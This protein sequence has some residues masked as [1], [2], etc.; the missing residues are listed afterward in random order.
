MTAAD[1][2]IS[3]GGTGGHVFPALA[4][5]EELVARGYARERG[6]LRR[7]PARP[8][9][10][11]GPG[12]R[13]RHRP[14]A[15]SRPPAGVP[16]PP[17]R[18]EPPHRVG[19]RRRRRPG[20]AAGAAAAPA[21]GRGRGRLRVG[22][23]AGRRPPLGRAGGG[24]R[25]RRPPRPGQ[26]DRGAPRCPPRGHPPRDAA[27]RGGG[28]RQSHPARHRRRAPGPGDTPA[29]RGGRRE[30]RGALAEPGGPRPLR[31]LAGPE[32]RHDP[33]RERCPRLRRVPHPAGGAAPTGRRARLPTGPV[34]GAHGGHLHRR[35]AGR[36]PLGRDDGGA[37]RGRGARGAGAAPRRARRPPDRER[38]GAGRGRRR[39]GGPRRRPRPGPPRH[40]ARP[41]CSPTPTVGRAMGDA[42]R[43]LGRPDATARFADL[44]EEVAGA[45]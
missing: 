44:V 3:G 20:G 6:P 45:R 40:R 17:G 1:V 39:G 42:A 21:R 18:A 22:P 11:R 31:P 19:H 13:L 33:P 23:G 41:R 5:A 35:R 24:A 38:G 8:R 4:L 37:H 2:L 26:P 36:L 12:R 15:R 14:P 32:R 29:G 28:H 16:P 43:A 27:P 10:D 25:G 30:P 34:R 7:R 9:G